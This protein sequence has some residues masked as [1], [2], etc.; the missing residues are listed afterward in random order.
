MYDTARVA[1]QGLTDDELFERVAL[2][3]LRTRFPEPRITGPSSDLNR[4]AFGRPLFGS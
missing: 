2:R 1:L 4:D 3:V